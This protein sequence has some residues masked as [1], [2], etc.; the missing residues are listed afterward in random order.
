MWD[1]LCINL[2]TA[3]QPLIR[4]AKDHY[5]QRYADLCTQVL[6]QYGRLGWELVGLTSKGDAAFKRS[7]AAA[8]SP[9]ATSAP[10]AQHAVSPPR[11]QD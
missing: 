11:W 7:L 2:G 5:Y 8:A 4:N 6:Q 10:T 1:Y 9:D 3:T